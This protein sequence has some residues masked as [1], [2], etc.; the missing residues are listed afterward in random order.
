[1]R[2]FVALALAL[3]LFASSGEAVVDPKTGLQKV[4][5]VPHSHCGAY[6]NPDMILMGEPV[7]AYSIINA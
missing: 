2:L 1:M 4:F 7:P 5:V 3:A 6:V